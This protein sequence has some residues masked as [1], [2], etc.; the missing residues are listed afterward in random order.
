MAAALEGLACTAASQDP[1]ACARLLGAGRRIR[2]DTGISLTVIEGHDPHEAGGHVRS[3]LGARQF[4]VAA[5]RGKYSSLDELLTL[6]TA[7]GASRSAP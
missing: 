2:E 3:V 1:E 7:A 5:D 6:A 4:A